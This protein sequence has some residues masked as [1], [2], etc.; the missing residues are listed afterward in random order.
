MKKQHLIAI[1]AG[2]ILALLLIIPLAL[3]QGSSLSSS[4]ESKLERY[5]ES[6]KL[7]LHFKSDGTPIGRGTAFVIN[8]SGSLVTN[9]HV[10][11]N[12]N[13]DGTVSDPDSLKDLFYIA[14]EKQLRDKRVVVMQRALLEKMDRSRDLALLRVNAPDK[15]Y[16]K[17]LALCGGNTR[18]DQG[19]AVRALGF[20]GVFDSDHNIVKLLKHMLADHIKRNRNYLDDRVELDWNVDMHNLLSV[21]SQAG[22][23]SVVQD[24]ASMHTGLGEDA[25]L[26]II[27]HSANLKGGMSGGPLIN[28]NGMVVGVNFGT[29]KQTEIINSA[30]HVNELIHF[31][32]PASGRIEDVAIVEADPDSLVYRV[33]TFIKNATMQE[34]VIVMCCAVVVIGAVCVL[35]FAL[36]GKKKKKKKTTRVNE[37]IGNKGNQGKTLP[38]KGGNGPTLPLGTMKSDKSS[39]SVVLSGSDNRGTKLRF[40]ISLKELRSRRIIPIGREMSSGGICLQYDEKSGISRRHAELVYEEDDERNGYVIIR[41]LKPTNATTVNG[42]ALRENEPVQLMDGDELQFG[43]VTLTFTAEQ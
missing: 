4:P 5:K 32:R 31:L 41:N 37:Y 17:P 33:T 26:N 24:S 40:R 3:L 39:P 38:M 2:L 22:E 14:Y 25:R 11:C 7:V 12:I 43:I 28:G 6:V 29:H 9:A 42:H 18:V 20:P 27:I 19:S 1:C 16:L 35:F 13:E 10:V 34:M 8:G 23:I 21:I 15:A 36:I 30:I